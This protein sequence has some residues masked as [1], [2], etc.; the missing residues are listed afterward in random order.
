MAKQEEI[1]AQASNT[2]VIKTSVFFRALIEGVF[3]ARIQKR[4]GTIWKKF[5]L[6]IDGLIGDWARRI[7][8]KMIPVG[9]DT[10]MFMTYRNDYDCNPK[11]IAEELIQQKAPYRLVWAIGKNTDIYNFPP[12]IKLVRRNSFEFFCEVASAKVWVDNSINFL[13]EYLPKKEG[14]IYIQ[15]WHGSMGLK[16]VGKEELKSNKRWL[17]SGRHCSKDTDFCI[18][19]SDFEDMVFRESHWPGVQILKYGHARNDILLSADL[20][21]V[22]AA[23]RRVYDFFNLKD[24]YKIILYAPTF[25]DNKSIEPYRIDYGKLVKAAQQRFGGDWVILTRHHFHIRNSQ[26]AAQSISKEQYV[27]NATQ[28]NDMQELMVAA[29]IGITDYSSWICDFMLT[30]KPGFIYATDIEQYYTERGFYYPLETTP[31]P[32]CTNNEELFESILDF[33]IE[34]YETKL[35]QFLLDRGCVEDG[36]ASERVAKKIMEIM[37]D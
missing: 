2:P 15:T 10:I 33:D 7:L 6:F 9:S 3:F 20:D 13:W 31:F 18:S 28:Y 26:M 36:H 14:Q 17:K 30:G 12:E 16:R 22:T 32:I 27:A 11:Y 29:D 4:I 23:K 37:G 19:N 24:T 1:M 5:W 34:Q 35:H 25:R 21:I 8:S